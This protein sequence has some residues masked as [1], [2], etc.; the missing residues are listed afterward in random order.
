MKDLSAFEKIIGISFA[1]KD[2]LRQAFVHRSYLNENKGLALEHNERLE[3]LGD[4]V[5]ELV[6]TDYLYH[7]YQ[8]PEGELTNLRA[9]VVRGE[10]LSQLAAEVGMESYMLLSRG[11]Q[12]GSEKARQYILA[13]AFEALIG[14]LYLDG[15]YEA[16][17]AFISR[18]VLAKL[19]E[20][21]SKGLH[22]DSKS[23]FQELA[24]ERFRITPTYEV[25]RE[26]GLDHAKQFVVGLFLGNRKV[27][28]GSGSSKQEAQQAAARLALEELI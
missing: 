20:V 10:M 1:N 12:K 2:L 11:E 16:A 18:V 27:S 24:Q 13:N 14:A 15:E 26:D 22:V 17:R 28:E 6:V 9:A 5:L 19:P 3:F 8:L 7:H 21:I 4:A 23:R 25:L